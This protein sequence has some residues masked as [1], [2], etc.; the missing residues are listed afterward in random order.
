MN[1][2]IKSKILFWLF[3]FHSATGFVLIQNNNKYNDNHNMLYNSNTW[4]FLSRG[5]PRQQDHP[6]N[7]VAPSYRNPLFS[8]NRLK[9]ASLTI[10][11]RHNSLSLFNIPFFKPILG[12][13]S[14]Q[15]KA[16]KKTTRKWAPLLTAVAVFLFSWF[17]PTQYQ[18]PA[19]A[20]E[21]SSIVNLS[22]QSTTVITRTNAVSTTTAAEAL[23]T[24]EKGFYDLESSTKMCTLLADESIA[25]GRGSISEVEDD[26]T[27]TT[28]ISQQQQEPQNHDG[29]MQH[30]EEDDDIS[31][32]NDE[33]SAIGTA[34]KAS[35]GDGGGGPS[36]EEITTKTRGNVVMKNGGRLLAATTG[37]G[38][39][40]AATK[41]ILSNEE[42]SRDDE[43]GKDV[44][45]NDSVSNIKR[46]DNTVIVVDQSLPLCDPEHLQARSQPK[47]S[48]EETELAVKYASISDV[49][50][51]AFQIL[52]DLG[53]VEM[54]P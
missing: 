52:V 4:Q 36:S 14:R 23:L 3:V 13:F 20:V 30:R 10:K 26:T 41:K 18:L 24:I 51:R 25:A 6:K 9:G 35:G 5:L 53:M 49:G 48:T 21:T 50:E 17:S 33:Q 39:L 38:L 29:D 46:D 42:D 22:S 28:N 37:T 15:I 45:M 43:H 7:I 32:T 34:T 11:D 1:R 54:H 12:F 16:N 40:V 27:T 19:H 8:S 47:S 44:I 31:T 2:Y